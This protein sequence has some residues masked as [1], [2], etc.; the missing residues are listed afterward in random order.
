M[1]ANLPLLA[2][3]IARRVPE[4]ARDS[5]TNNAECIERLL[6]GSGADG[7]Q[8][9]GLTIRKLGA[10]KVWI[11]NAGGEALETSEAKLAATLTEFFTREF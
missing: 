3:D 6:R 4:M 9:G 5:A 8:V 11:I 7:F 10:G 2:A 1:N